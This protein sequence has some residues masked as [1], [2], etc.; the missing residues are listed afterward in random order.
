VNVPKSPVADLTTDITGDD[1]TVAPE[2][3]GVGAGEANTTA[4]VNALGNNGAT[5]YSATLADDLVHNGYT[6]SF[7]PTKVSGT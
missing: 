4:I 1:D 2:F 3:E 5:D 6:D 7:L